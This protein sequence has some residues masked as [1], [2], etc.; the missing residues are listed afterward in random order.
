MN[1]L[2]FVLFFVYTVAMNVLYYDCFSG[3]SGDMNLGVMVDLGVPQDHLI[4]EL[5][6]LNINEEFNL[7]FETTQKMGITGIK[8]HVELT[9]H[10]HDHHGKSGDHHHR[11]LDDIRH[12]LESSISS[13]KF[14]I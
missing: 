10:H 11:C 12:I 2:G 1:L 7:T 6:E 3:I 14:C 9:G 4:K 13:H 5:S 8:A